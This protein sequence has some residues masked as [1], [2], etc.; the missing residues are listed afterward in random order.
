MRLDM[1]KARETKAR[2]KRAVN[3]AATLPS[4]KTAGLVTLRGSRVNAA[5]KLPGAYVADHGAGL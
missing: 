5:E 2:W 3:L 4:R 1:A